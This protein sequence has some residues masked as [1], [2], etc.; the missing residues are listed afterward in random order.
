MQ[1]L[2]YIQNQ[3]LVLCEN[4]LEADMVDKLKLMN[5]AN[6]LERLSRESD[7]LK[8]ENKSL[9]NYFERAEDKTALVRE[10]LSMDV[11][12]GKG[13]VQE[14]ENLKRSINERNIEIE[15]LKKKLEQQDLES[16][17]VAMKE[18]RDH[19]EQSLQESNKTL[20]IVVKSIDIVPAVTVDAMFEDPVEKVKWLLQCYHDFQVS[21]SRAEQ[22]LETVNQENI[23]MS[24]K[25]EEAYANIKSLENELLKS[26]E[27]LSLMIQA[28]QDIESLEEA[29]SSIERRISTLVEEKAAAEEDRTNAENE[30]EKAKA[31]VETQVSEL[32]EVSQ[33]IKSL[34]EALSSAKNIIS[35]FA[36]E[37]AAAEANQTVKSLKEA[38]SSAESII[39][40]LAE[41]KSVVELYITNAENE[42]HKAKA[43][44]DSQ[45]SEL[46]EANQ[47]IK[48]LE[49]ALSRAEKHAFVLSKERND[50][51]VARDLLD[52]E[53][54]EPKTE[55]SVQASEV[56]DAYTTIKSLEDALAN[57]ENDIVV[58]VNEKRNTEHEIVTLNAK[59]SSFVED[60]AGTRGAAKGQ[61]VELL[62]H[63]NYLEMLMKDSALL[64]LLTQGFKK[65]LESL[66]DMHLLL[67]GT[68]DRFVEKGSGLLHVRA[69][70]EKEHHLENISPPDHE[71]FHYDTM[72][73]SEGSAAD[74][75][76]ISSYFTNIIK[77]FNMKNKLIKDNFVGF[78]GSMDDY[79]AVFTK[80]LQQTMDG[81]VIT[82]ETMEYLKQQDT[83]DKMRF[84]DENLNSSL[85]SGEREAG[86][87]SVEEQQG[88]LGPEGVKVT[89]LNLESVTQERDLHQS[90]ASKL[91][92]SL[93]ELKSSCNS[94]N[95]KLDECLA[96]EDVSREKEAELSSLHVSLAIKN[97]EEE[98]RLLSEGQ[99][100][101]LLEKINGIEIPFRVSELE[102]TEIFCGRS[103]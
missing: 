71:K 5:L 66:R 54:E 42:L 75:E 6:E 84:E 85:F 31:G 22:D 32:V 16:Y 3:K 10:K 40:I 96:M 58:L 83:V 24:S 57:A 91:E 55:A 46:A 70:T 37:K 18:Q 19:F 97:Q 82:L 23:S 7:A 87:D 95:L 103:C 99:I 11:K 93:E 51:Q 81:V 13:M 33:T 63:L 72:H 36:E 98:G 35:I 73:K 28:K 67:E 90:R 89:K 45:A 53:L 21:K 48:S 88:L 20:Q 59:L 94:M 50:F 47:S 86:G 38:L 30:L 44:V 1:S 8:D 80:A 25:L 76:N 64:F 56:S 17:F 43:G 102:N 78:S 39:S 4:I 9:Q 29:V 100:Q 14:R 27:D 101:T 77:R 65:K 61:S 15:K 68:R 49:D 52:K 62:E 60:L 79:V 41:E 34:E 12:K 69:G 26:S 2:L 74:S 92:T